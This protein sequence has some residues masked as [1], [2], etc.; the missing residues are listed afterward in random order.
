MIQFMYILF[1][2]SSEPEKKTT[3]ITVYT[4]TNMDILSIPYIYIFYV[5]LLLIH[6]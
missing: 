4:I 2:L 1:V 5:C 3:E 6:G